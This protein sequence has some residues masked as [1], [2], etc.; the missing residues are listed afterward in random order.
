[1]KFK[2]I[3]FINDL[4]Q[5]GARQGSAMQKGAE[6]IIRVLK[7]NKIEHKVE[8]FEI[9][10]PVIEKAFL[11]VDGED[12]PCKGCSTVSGIIDKKDSIVSSLIS[13]QYLIDV[14][15]INFNPN[16]EAISQSNFYFVPSVAISRENLEKVVLAK[17]IR[18]EVEVERWVGDS[19]HIL[20]GNSLS[21]KT[22]VFAHYDSIGPGAIDNASGV[23]TSLSLLIEKPS[24]LENTLFVFDGNEELSYDM[25]VYWGHGFRVF[26]KKYPNLFKVAKQ[27]IAVDC[28]GNGP[29]EVI[30]DPK[31]I[32]LAFPIDNIDLHSSK[33]S[34]IGAN[35]EH[36]MTVYHSDLDAPSLIEEKYL[37][38]AEKLI[39][40]IL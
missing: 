34:T 2:S 18:G 1:M 38:Q 10:I 31:I 17:K 5:L 30:T 13:S 3:Q 23:A 16:C 26:Q 39:L 9:T 12:V 27:I 25:P 35:I 11:N 7:D 24:L 6:L 20:V 22:I 19:F 36:L 21:P 28:V 40:T 29:S 32:K 15:N 37:E 4:V 8:P 33:I 14:P